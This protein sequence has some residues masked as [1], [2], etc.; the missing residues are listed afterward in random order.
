MRDIPKSVILTR[1]MDSTK[2]FRAAKSRCTTALEARYLQIEKVRSKL[3][4]TRKL[5]LNLLHSLGDLGNH[6]N[7]RVE[8]D[9]N[10][11]IPQKPK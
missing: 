2:T 9:L 1:S 10:V 8:I 5:D 3:A 7:F 4:R 11:A 6:Q